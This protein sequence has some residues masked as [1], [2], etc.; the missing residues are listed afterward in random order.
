MSDPYTEIKSL[1]KQL[2]EAREEIARLNQASDKYCIAWSNS[3]A[4]CAR[5]KQDRDEC[6]RQLEE[7]RI[8]FAEASHQAG[9]TAVHVDQLK[10]QLVASEA[11]LATLLEDVNYEGGI[12]W[13]T[14]KHHEALMDLANAIQLW[15][16]SESKR[17]QMRAKAQ[18]ALDTFRKVGEG[19]AKC[20]ELLTEIVSTPPS[21]ALRAIRMEWTEKAFMEGADMM[22]TAA[23]VKQGLPKIA[24][25]NSETRREIM[26]GNSDAN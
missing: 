26:G 10:E 11:K 13:W 20:R 5:L 18:A 23:D 2:A 17:E 15:M 19:P 21:E 25:D 8:C 12:P 14:H 9:P 4:E 22:S 7:L 16:E 6:E 1:R 24:W 3:D